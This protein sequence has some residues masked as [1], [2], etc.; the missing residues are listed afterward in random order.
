MC[1]VAA[2]AVCASGSGRAPSP[3][4]GVLLAGSAIGLLSGL[5][6]VGGGVFL[7]ALLLLFR[8]ADPKIAA[9]VSAPFVFVNSAA[10]LAGHS[11][12]LH[13]LPEVWPWL[14]AAV[15]TGG[16]LGA[17]WGSGIARPLH[18]R[19]ALVAVLVVASVKLLFE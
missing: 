9:A 15:V 18:L 6:G 5:I 11:A 10:G 3:I 16:F 7:T 14:V 4:A 1:R 8:W 2:G 17:R 19:P 12:S 13:G